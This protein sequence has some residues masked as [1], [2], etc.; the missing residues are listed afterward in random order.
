MSTRP[1]R[2]TGLRGVVEGGTVSRGSKSERAALW[3]TVGGRRLLLRRKDGPGFGDTAL[4]AFRGQ[5]VVCDGFVIETTLLV[6]RIG[7]AP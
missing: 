1:V 7:L 2:V 6:E 3:I 5:E 4:D